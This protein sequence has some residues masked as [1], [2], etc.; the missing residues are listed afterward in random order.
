MINQNMK[1]G[2]HTIHVHGHRKLVESAQLL[3]LLKYADKG[4]QTF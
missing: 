4:F 2:K 1:A 3:K